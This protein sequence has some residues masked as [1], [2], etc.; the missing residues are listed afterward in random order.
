MGRFTNDIEK[1]AEQCI[2]DLKHRAE[3][4]GGRI[5]EL[6]PKIDHLKDSLESVEDLFFARFKHTETTDA[7]SLGAQN[8]ANLQKVLEV[9]LK[10]VLEGQAEVA[11]SYEKSIRLANQRAASTVDTAMQAVAL[12]VESAEHLRTQ[13]ELSRL[14]A[15][16]L[17]SRQSNLEEGMNR[18]INI[19]ENLA[20][21]YDDHTSLLRQAHNITNA[22]LVTLENT[23]ASAVNINKSV[24][25][26]LANSSWWPIWCPAASLVLGSYGLPPSGIR[27]LA[28]LTL[29]AYLIVIWNQGTADI[30]KAK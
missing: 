2:I 16:E 27:N 5:D 4:T 19:T 7:V 28:L 29:G 20:I 3:T 14:Q 13:V 12:V 17:E 9:V 24:L 22:I 1:Q 23:A 30:R 15:A 6:S 25:K 21:K 18:L 10:S 8:A 26:Q 11:S